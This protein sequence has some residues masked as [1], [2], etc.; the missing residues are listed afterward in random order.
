MG[1]RELS[2]NRTF[3]LLVAAAFVLPIA[4]GADEPQWEAMLGDLIKSEKAGYGGLCGLIVEPGSG[5]VIINVS[6]RGFYRST[7]GAKS[8]K[9]IHETPIKGR[10]ESPGCLM[11]DPTGKTNTLLAALVYGAPI[12]SSTDGGVHWKPM[13]EKITHIDWCAIDWNDPEHQFVLALKHEQGELMLVS[14]DAGKTFS[15]VG[16]GYGPAWIFNGTTA[17]AAEEKTKARPKPNLVRTEDAGKTWKP[18]GEYTPVGSASNRTMPKWH[19]GT[20]YW[21]VEGALVT[22]TD[23]GK[24]WNKISDVKA[25]RYGPVFGKA[26]GHL[27]ILTT[28]GI[29]ESSDGGTN[30]GKPIPLPKELKAGGLTW[31]DYDSKGD[32]L[33]AMKMTSDLYKLNRGK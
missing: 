5:D 6:D 2:M 7:D 14:T 24:T 16:K 12:Q 9:R 8:F 11:I 4:R 22:T 25:G 3:S 23:A 19:D 1:A 32:Q 18:C 17:V 20:L 21:L 13:N 27:F 26:K 33:Y 29:V 30:W 28:E 15:E 10:T 31:I